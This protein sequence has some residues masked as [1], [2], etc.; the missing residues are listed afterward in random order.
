M[1]K[2]VLVNMYST[3]RAV[4]RAIGEILVILLEL[5]YSLTI[6]YFVAKWAIEYAYSVR[7]YEAYGGE[8]IL[9]IMAF[10]LSWISIHTFFRL[11]RREGGR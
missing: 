3:G 9:I 11:L 2:K 8:Y 10:G 6:T 4:I 7:G 5:F 1:V